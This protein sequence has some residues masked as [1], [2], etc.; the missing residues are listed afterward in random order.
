MTAVSPKHRA[1]R[2][3]LSSLTIDPDALAKPVPQPGERDFLMCGSPRSGTALLVATLFQPPSAV[4]VME[5][6]DALRLPPRDLF[7]SLREE[8]LTTGRLARG[9]MDIEALEQRGSVA[10]C[11]DGERPHDVP[12][13]DENFLLGVKFPAFWRYLDLLPQ[14]RFLVCLRHPLEVIRSYEHTGGRLREG[15]DYGVPFNRR[16]NEHL[17]AA[18]DDS[19]IRRVLLYDYVHERILP[20]LGRPNVLVVR[21]ERWFT[22]PARQ[23]ADISAFLDVDLD[24]SRVRLRQPRSRGDAEREEL[25]FLRKSCVT[26]SALGYEL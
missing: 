24:G 8:L 2:R 7:E 18:T 22:E 1:W 14:T 11:R 25:A 10:W 9:R 20:H 12:V 21:Y 4:T 6:W 26:A 15:L 16:M 17:L 3:L 13:D 5:P 23:L 19:A